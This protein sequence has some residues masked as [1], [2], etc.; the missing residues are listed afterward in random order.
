MFAGRTVHPRFSGGGFVSLRHRLF[1]K[2]VD[3]TS[4]FVGSIVEVLTSGANGGKTI[5]A[6]RTLRP[7]HDIR[8][9]GGY[10][11]QP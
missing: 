8:G 6:F 7:D 11:F 3:R 9:P 10:A 4:A 5:F 1:P 2:N